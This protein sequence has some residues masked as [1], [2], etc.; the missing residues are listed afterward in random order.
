MQV[1]YNNGYLLKWEV[2]MLA[3]YDFS[4]RR[5][6]MVPLLAQIYDLS[7]ASCAAAS[8]KRVIPSPPENFIFWRQR[9]Y[10]QL[11]EVPRRWLVAVEGNVVAGVLFYYHE[12]ANLHIDT[13]H[14]V[15]NHPKYTAVVVGLLDKLALDPASKDADFFVD[16]E[17]LG[18]WAEAKSAL[19]LR[20]TKA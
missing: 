9:M 17:V 7:L 4:A 13:L 10:K 18:R 20:Y 14:I 16:G 5:G 19:T 1:V 3:F 6:A 11:V 12:N 2:A 15:A 8:D